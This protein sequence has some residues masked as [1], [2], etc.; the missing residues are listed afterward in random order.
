MAAALDD[1]VG[2][3]ALPVALVVEVEVAYS[4]VVGDTRHNTDPYPGVDNRPGPAGLR[5]AAVAPFVLPG[6][7]VAILHLIHVH[8][9]VLQ[10]T[11]P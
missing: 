11:W 2:V 1:G 10:G 3:V 5:S 6:K 7:P 4:P 9:S 8:S